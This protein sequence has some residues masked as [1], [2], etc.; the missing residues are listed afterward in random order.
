[1]PIAANSGSSQVLLCEIS[2]S[3]VPGEFKA[4]VNRE[5]LIAP[6]RVPLLDAARA[7]IARRADSNAWLIMRQAGSDTDCQR[8]K[9]GLLAQMTVRS[10]NYGTPK[11]RRMAQGDVSAS[12][13]MRESGSSFAEGS[14]S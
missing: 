4:V 10:N 14:A 11:L 12:A 3:G 8:G 1:M 13:L 6:S 2:P 7:L 9:I 5:L